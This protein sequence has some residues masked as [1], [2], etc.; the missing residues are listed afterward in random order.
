MP[1]PM[2]F[3]ATASNV[4][5]PVIF[6]ATVSD[7]LCHCQRFSMP[8]SMMFYATARDFP[9][10]CQQSSVPLP[11]KFYAFFVWDRADVFT[12]VAKNVTLISV[13]KFI[14]WTLSCFSV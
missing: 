1:L 6:R 14:C 5:L 13:C 2:M 12:T 9:C 4:P 11:A 8:L 3:Y 7:V 10:H